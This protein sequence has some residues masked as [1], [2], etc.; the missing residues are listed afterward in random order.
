MFK[1]SDFFFSF[2]LSCYIRHIYG[3]EFIWVSMK[4]MTDVSVNL[5][6]QNA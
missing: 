3:V 2:L 6:V 4:C 1:S 5:I